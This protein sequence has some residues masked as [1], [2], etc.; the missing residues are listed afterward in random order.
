MEARK[1]C[2]AGEDVNGGGLPTGSRLDRGTAMAESWQPTLMGMLPVVSPP[3]AAVRLTWMPLAMTHHLISRIWV[4]H[5][6]ALLVIREEEGWVF[7][8]AV[9]VVLASPRRLLHSA[10]AAVRP[11][12]TT[13]ASMVLLPPSDLASPLQLA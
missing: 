9:V 12:L 8:D 5:G 7:K 1:P 6:L 3:H 11:R 10:T 13:G 2:E 4:G